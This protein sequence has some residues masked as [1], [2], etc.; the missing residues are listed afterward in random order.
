MKKG[1][2]NLREAKLWQRESDYRFRTDK[3]A[4]SSL[5]FANNLWIQNKPDV[6]TIFNARANCRI[7]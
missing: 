6:A 1:T 7:A 5:D 2:G 3:I 4:E